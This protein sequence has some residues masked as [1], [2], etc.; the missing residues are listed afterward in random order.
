MTSRRSLEKRLAALEDD[1][2][3]LESMSA[4]DLY[5]L[6]LD[7]HLGNRE[8]SDATIERAEQIRRERIEARRRGGPSAED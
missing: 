3:G 7:G 6:I 1:G 2:D 4:A 5:A 8:V